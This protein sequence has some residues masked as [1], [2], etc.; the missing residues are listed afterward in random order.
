MKTIILA[1]SIL[2]FGLFGC[3]TESEDGS[4]GLVGYPAGH[5][6][7]TIGVLKGTGGSSGYMGFGI[8]KDTALK[9]ESYIYFVSTIDWTKEYPRSY[10]VFGGMKYIPLI[11]QGG[12]CLTFPQS[13]K[14]TVQIDGQDV[15]VEIVKEPCIPFLYEKDLPKE[16]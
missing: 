6:G 3:M 12:Q 13:D 5:V 4:P 8:F 2:S 11:D 16:L 15:I 9:V 7:S 14:D 10:K 1:I